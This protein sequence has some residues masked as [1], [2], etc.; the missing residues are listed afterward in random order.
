[1]STAA[2]QVPMRAP[3]PTTPSTVR[4]L[5]IDKQR[6]I[7]AALPKHIAPGYFLRVVLTAVQK[8]PKLAECTPLSFLG[9]VLQCAQ[10]G[11]VPDGFLGQAYLIPFRNN[12]RGVWEV[13]FQCGYRGLITLARRSAEISTVT[14][15]VVYERDAFKQIRGLRPDIEHVPYDGDED[16]GALVHVYS[17]YRLKDGGYDLNV[18]NRRQV[19][20]I[21]DRSQAYRTG[22]QYGKKDSPWFT[23]EA[24]MWRKTS[25]KQLLKLAPLSIEIQRASG[26]DDAAEAGLPQDL[27]ILADP[28]AEATALLEGDSDE[29]SAEAI[30]TEPVQPPP[31][32]KPS[33]KPPPPPPPPPATAARDGGH[34][35]R[36]TD[37]GQVKNGW[38]AHTEGGMRIWTR[39]PALAAQ[40]E[41]SK[42]ER[43]HL[44]LDPPDDQ[45]RRHV[46]AIRDTW[47]PET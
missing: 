46:T 7:G 37:V 24:W 2:A 19:H 47:D 34:V 43:R 38:A 41:A 20:A 35:D 22:M 30:E 40:L 6:E 45:G 16:P 42:G 44:T 25:L 33:P 3:S 26:L 15:E 11:L 17:F 39:N 1:M 18:M 23:D 4:Q 36:I 13:Q 8:N 31:K 12:K 27:A 14:A 28:N 10:L 32:P 29:E 21:R 5:L 9:A